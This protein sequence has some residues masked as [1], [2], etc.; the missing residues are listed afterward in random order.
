MKT[1]IARLSL[2]LLLAG[3]MFSVAA[4]RDLKEIREQGVLRH[5]G[6]PYANFVSGS[7]QGLDVEL[8]QLFARHLG[9]RYE[10]VPATW[11][12]VIA[13]L[14]GREITVEGERVIVTG[15]APIRG[16]VI[17]NGLT[18]LPWRQKVLSFSAPTFPTQVWLITRSE[19]P[20]R[21]I[22]PMGSLNEDIGLVKRL[23]AGRSV[24]GVAGTC[25]DPKLYNLDAA[26][27]ESRLFTGSLNELAP[28]VLK[29][30]ADTALLD[31]PDSL[32][33][34]AKW[35]GQV[36]ILGPVS[37]PQE[38]AVGFRKDS[39]ELQQAFAAFFARLKADGTY[40][41]MVRKYYPDVF[42]YYPDFFAVR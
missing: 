39:P 25:L 33:A 7:D 35:P 14:T 15:E 6:V 20:L 13:D 36:K 3:A 22:E 10:Y 42:A 11:K 8:M 24:L 30:E 28:A 32:V 34:L 19:S 2:A 38:M 26:K 9:V 5:L 23:M 21:P 31:V 16:D 40:G 1:M 18:V 4:A 12:T 17:A 27:A 29:Q 41:G 37:E